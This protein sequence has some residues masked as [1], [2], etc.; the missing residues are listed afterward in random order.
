M[1]D[2][3][4]R[5]RNYKRATRPLPARHHRALET[6][7]RTV[8]DHD[9]R[10]GTNLRLKHSVAVIIT[11]A[12]RE[13]EVSRHDELAHVISPL[14]VAAVKREI[15]N[16]REIMVDALYPLMGRLVAAYAVSGFRD[17]LYETDRRLQ[18]ALSGRSARLRWK[19]MLLGIPYRELAL[20]ERPG[21]IVQELLLID[22]CSG[23]PLDRWHAAP[24]STSAR[25]NSGALFSALLAAITGFASEALAQDRGELRALDLGSSRVYVRATPAYLVAAKCIGKPTRDIERRLEEAF[26]S[27]LDEY[28]HDLVRRADSNVAKSAPPILPVLAERLNIALASAER[29]VAGQRR[30]PVLALG[31]LATVASLALVAIG[32]PVSEAARAS[33]LRERVQN[34]ITRTAALKGYPLGVEIASN[35]QSVIV[36]GLAPSLDAGAELAKT[37]ADTVG[38]V[39]VTLD[40]TYLSQ[41]PIVPRSVEGIEPLTQRVAVLEADLLQSLSDRVQAG[42]V[43]DVPR[44]LAALPE[45]TLQPV[46]AAQLTARLDRLTALVQSMVGRLRVALGAEASTPLSELSLDGTTNIGAFPNFLRDQPIL[47]TGIDWKI[48]DEENLIAPLAS[49]GISSGERLSLIPST[50]I[51]GILGENVQLHLSPIIEV[52]GIG[53]IDGRSLDTPTDSAIDKTFSATESTLEKAGSTV[54]NVHSKGKLLGIK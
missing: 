31:S 26:Y 34:A 20:R 1:S 11:D 13:A 27:F 10:V 17:F 37:I 14:I 39:P 36:K 6:I 2:P 19:S 43:A 33:Q 12:L 16:S 48:A 49:D 54:E 45:K 23:V 8:D 32:Y 24:E 25:D 52:P 47:E 29:E 40:L 18:N 30:R 21:L 53:V 50:I 51:G 38:P 42:I 35:G 5:V 4:F 3:S 15:T 22:K 46:S 28:S 44:A 7:R 41:S 9:Q